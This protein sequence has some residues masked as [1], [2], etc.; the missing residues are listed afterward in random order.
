[1]DQCVYFQCGQALRQVRGMP[2]ERQRLLRRQAQLR[3]QCP[4]LASIAP[5]HQQMDILVGGQHL[6]NARA[7]KTVTA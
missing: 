7:E 1:M 2:V 3:R 6:A 4:G 5:C